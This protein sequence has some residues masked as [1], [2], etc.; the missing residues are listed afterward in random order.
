M[1]KKTK[2]ER[3]KNKISTNYVLIFDFLVIGIYLFTK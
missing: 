1:F 2:K 3:R